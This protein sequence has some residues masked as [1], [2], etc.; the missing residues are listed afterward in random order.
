MLFRRKD[1]VIML[2]TA[3]LF[4]CVIALCVA[5][6]PQS[7]NIDTFQPVM[8]SS[9]EMGTFDGDLFGYTAVLHK[10][11]RDGGVGDTQ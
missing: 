9:P 2:R 1:F 3:Y 11:N 6:Q 10:P 8:R 4:H 5:Q 7:D